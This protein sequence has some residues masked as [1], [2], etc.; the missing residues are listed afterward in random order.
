MK[1]YFFA[2][3][4]FILSFFFLFTSVK[5]LENNSDFEYLRVSYDFD[6]DAYYVTYTFKPSEYGLRNYYFNLMNIYTDSIEHNVSDFE[7]Q[8]TAIK[9]SADIIFSLNESKEYYIKFK[10]VF[11]EYSISFEPFLRYKPSNVFDKSSAPSVDYFELKIEHP[12]KIDL[13]LDKIQGVDDFILEKGEGTFIFL[14]GD[15]YEVSNYYDVTMYRK[16]V[17][18]SE[19][20]EQDEKKHFIYFILLITLVTIYVCFVL[21]EKIM[22][23]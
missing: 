5:A 17:L 13:T 15:R 1:K 16:I 11:P 10:G 2:M 12:E 8:S 9:N 14:A 4:V 6:D 7:L 20:I 21:K 19:E 18:L 3:I 22:D 23:F